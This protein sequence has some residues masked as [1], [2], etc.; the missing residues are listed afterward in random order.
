[1]LFT[2]RPRTCAAAKQTKTA[3]PD[4]IVRHGSTRT[5]LRQRE[6]R[7]ELDA[8][9]T[10]IDQRLHDMGA[11]GIDVQAISTSPLQYYYRIEPELGRETA[12]VINERLAEIVEAHPDRFVA[13]QFMLATHPS[14]PV[15][16]IKELVAFAKSRPG[17]LT[18]ASSGA[19]CIN[20]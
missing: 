5:A 17:K 9:L 3:E 10:S 7:R 16:S 12:R 11:M 2:C 1:M 8:K 14:V 6:L 13:G 15:K 4:P 19:G 18:Y 20:Q